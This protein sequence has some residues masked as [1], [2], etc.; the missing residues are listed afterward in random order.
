MLGTFPGARLR[1]IKRGF[2][3]RYINYFATKSSPTEHIFDLWEARHREPTA[4]TDLLN[5]LRVMG[6]CDA[7]SILEQELGAWL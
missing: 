7:A 6:R 4:V 1:K 2:R 5:T 3:I